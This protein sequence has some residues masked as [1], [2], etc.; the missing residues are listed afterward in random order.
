[1]KSNQ[2]EFSRKGEAGSVVLTMP[3]D[4]DLLGPLLGNSLSVA[5]ARDIVEERRRQEEEERRE[6]AREKYLADIRE[7]LENEF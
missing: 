6:L 4:Q 1:M 3:Q 5:L 7:A 2:A